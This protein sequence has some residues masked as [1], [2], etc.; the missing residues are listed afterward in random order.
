[1]SH[2]FNKIWIHAIWATKDRKPLIHHS[3]E[4][5]IHQILTEQ[6]KEQ[7]CPVRIINGMPDHIHLFIGIKPSC[8]LSDLVREIKKSSNDFIKENKLSKY[9]FNWQE[10]F[11][12]FSYSH[13]HIDNVYKYIMNQKEHHKKTSF[14]DEYLD[15]LNKFQVEFDDKYIFQWIE[16]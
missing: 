7:G 4:Q 10:G 16:Y 12:A 6:L 2:S 13:S 3:S 8:C 5:K 11:G 9:K 1:M 14:K 15:F